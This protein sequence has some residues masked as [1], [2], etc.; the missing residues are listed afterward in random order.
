MTAQHRRWTNADQAR[1]EAALRLDAEANVRYAREVAFV[2]SRIYS[3]APSV[4]TMC[5]C[6]ADAP[7]EGP[8]K[9]GHG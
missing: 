4:P 1:L 6:T 2:T 9:P 5:Q 8:S 3:T 7:T